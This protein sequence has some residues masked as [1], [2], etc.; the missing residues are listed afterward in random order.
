MADLE[1]LLSSSANCDADLDKESIKELPFVDGAVFDSYQNQHDE[2][3]LPGTRTDILSQ[4]D[5]WASAQAPCMFW[6]NGMAGTGKST[7]SRTVA[8]SFSQKEILGASFFFK[9]GEADRGNAL[10]L[11][12]TVARQLAFSIPELHTYLQRAV[13]ENPGIGGREIQEQFDKLLLQ[14]L[15][16]LAQSDLQRRAVVIVV[17]ALDECDGDKSIRLVLQLLSN[18]RNISTLYLRVK[19]FLTSRPELPIRLGFLDI[20]T[21]EITTEKHQDLILHEIP[22]N[23]ITHDISLFFHHRLSKIRRE[24]FLFDDWPGETDFR[25]LVNLSIPL[26]IFAATIC[27]L[28]E[29]PNWDPIDSLTEV[30]AHRYDSNLDQTYLPVLNRVLAGQSE[31]QK[32]KLIQEFQQVIGP[33]VILESPLSVPSLSKLLDLPE[34]LIQLRLKLLHSVLQIPPEADKDSPVR[35]FHLSFKD[36]LLDPETRDKTPLSID[37]KEACCNL[38]MRCLLVCQN[39]LQ[40]N[41]CELPSEGTYRAEIDQATIDRHIPTELQYSCRYWVHHLLQCD[42]ANLIDQSFSFLQR[43]FLHWVEVL[44][45]L[46]RVSEVVGIINEL[47]AEI[48]VS[49]SLLYNHILSTNTYSRYS[50]RS[51][52]TCLIFSTMQSSSYSKIFRS[53]MMRLCKS[54]LPA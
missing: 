44:S 25:R 50:V 47:Q 34:S 12:P 10:K 39:Q 2:E 43:H 4:I 31:R 52:A 53:Q 30:L 15:V 7:I 40:K 49:P 28:F 13:V 18:L 36:F 38:A 5:M 14:P 26:F 22:E 23:V 37:K 46:G 16:C 11:F 33:I 51:I 41:I 1:V 42:L 21:S 48:P 27:R 45:L 35:V 8:R 29:D 19:V 32:N 3:C 6:L 17:D 9:R 24:S 20:A 54:T